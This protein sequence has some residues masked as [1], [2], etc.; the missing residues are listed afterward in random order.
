M[1]VIVFISAIDTIKKRAVSRENFRYLIDFFFSRLIFAINWLIWFFW[2]NMN[3]CKYSNNFDVKNVDVK[4]WIITR[5]E[6]KLKSS[7]VERLNDDFWKKLRF[8]MTKSCDII[9]N[10]IAWNLIANLSFLID[11][12][13]SFSSLI[14]VCVIW[15]RFL[16]LKI[17]F[18]E[19]TINSS[20]FDCENS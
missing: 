15:I 1:L 6:K 8:L 10:A 2:F 4:V 18:D 3:D 17:K 5:V 12:C 19:I 9:E 14:K 20:F 11:V 13:M 16:N 7:K